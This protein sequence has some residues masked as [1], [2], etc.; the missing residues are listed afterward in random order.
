MRDITKVEETALDNERVL[1]GK[2]EGRVESRM[3][4]GLVKIR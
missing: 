3:A 2:N 1:M 4:W